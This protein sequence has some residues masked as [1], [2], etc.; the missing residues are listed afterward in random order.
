M[1]SSHVWFILGV[2]TGQKRGCKR[3]E[4]LKS[5]LPGNAA[6]LQHDRMGVVSGANARSLA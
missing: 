1:H 4:T 6:T 5:R 2:A 3:G